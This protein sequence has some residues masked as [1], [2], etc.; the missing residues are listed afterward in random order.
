[1][2]GLRLAIFWALTAIVTLWLGGFL[3]VFWFDDPFTSRLTRQD[4]M[5]IYAASYLVLVW[6]TVRDCIRRSFPRET[7][8]LNWLVAVLLTAPI[9]TTLYYLMVVRKDSAP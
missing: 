6:L 4:V 3:W 2:K 7:T 1:M 8:K 5:T 9:G